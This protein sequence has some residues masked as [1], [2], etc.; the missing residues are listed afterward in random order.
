MTKEKN[1]SN[2]VAMSVHGDGPAPAG[3]K[4]SAGTLGKTRLGC[5]LVHGRHMIGA[6]F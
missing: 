4:T 5:R 6:D 3:A 2:Y 1:M